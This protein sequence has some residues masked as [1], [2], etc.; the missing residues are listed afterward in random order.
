MKKR[1][2]V[3][4]A[5]IVASS[6]L[7]AGCGEETVSVEEDKSTAT[8]EAEEVKTSA[9][10]VD[11][12]Q[13]ELDEFT[14]L[15]DTAEYN[16]FLYSPFNS[17][18]EIEWCDVFYNGAGIAKESISKTE[19]NAYL[20]ASGCDF[21]ETDLTGIAAGDIRDF[22]E[23]HADIK[24]N[25]DEDL[26]DWTYVEKYDTYYFQHGD[27]NYEPYTCTSGKRLDNVYV[28][29][30]KD[31]FSDENDYSFYPDREITL[32]K[33]DSGC[34]LKSNAFLWE[35]NNDPEQ[36]FDFDVSWSDTPYRL[37]TYQGDADTDT[38]AR[39]IIT[40][41]NKKID[42]LISYLYPEYDDTITMYDIA[43]VGVF[44]FTGDGL[45]DMVVVADCD[46]GQRHMALYEATTY[47]QDDEIQFFCLPDASLWLDGFVNGELNIPNI[48]A[49]LLG[50]N[51]DGK[52][53]TWQEAYTQ[54][55]KILNCDG[56]VTFSLIYLDGDDVPELVVD[57]SWYY[58]SVFS[59]KDGV[60]KPVIS[61]WSYGVGGIDEYYYA[62]QSGIVT[63]TD[64][65]E[66]QTYYG[67]YDKATMTIEVR[68]DSDE[69][70]DTI[71]NEASEYSFEDLR[72]NHDYISFL[73]Y[74]ES[75]EKQ[76]EYTEDYLPNKAI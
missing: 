47:N 22:I 44:D 18:E 42:F 45:T 49:Y 56:D 29:D 38:A 74:I 70:Y 72:G 7:L 35:K 20:E 15:F 67:K 26:L 76:I 8:D 60:A 36:T 55:A 46:D 34:V 10:A 58:I 12:T 4:T 66:M 68:S 59:F 33:T 37:V 73:D 71:Y 6:A 14:D 43:A 24:L 51:T 9:E 17:P 11:L 25:D 57:K 54:V 40:K 53:S 48:K 61:H 16:G 1:L 52:Y 5:I 23:S 32:E 41:D 13:D 50:D 69:G 3:A 21:L 27:S 63:Y 30:F 65:Y 75:L 31:D 64:T 19:K 28:L 39:M 2:M 62:P